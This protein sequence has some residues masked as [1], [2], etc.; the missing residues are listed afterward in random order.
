MAERYTS[1]RRGGRRWLWQRITAAFLIVVLAFH[2]FLLH[3]V[4]HA[5]EVTFGMTQGR[6]Q[7]L[8]YFSLMVLFLITAT[9]HGVNGVYNALINQGVTGKKKIIMKLVLSAAS[10][11]LI[12][13]GLRTAVVWADGVPI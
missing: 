7:E 8:A 6:M 3:F 5:N 12:A 10:L 2:F 1:F 9:F 4:H 13:Q 11:L